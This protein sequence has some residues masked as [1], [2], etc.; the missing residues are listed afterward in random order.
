MSVRY[1]DIDSCCTLD[2]PGPKRVRHPAPVAWNATPRVLK[3][4]RMEKERALSLHLISLIESM[5]MRTSV[6]S[7]QTI[8]W[9]LSNSRWP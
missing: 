9:L 3:G 4:L 5:R 8:L 6:T 2:H 7:S 1:A